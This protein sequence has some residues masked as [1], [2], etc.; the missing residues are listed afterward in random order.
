MTLRFGEV[1]P[2]DGVTRLSVYLPLRLVSALNT[3]EH[4]FARHRRVKSERRA[5]GLVVR[6]ALKGRAMPLP[7]VV[8]ITRIS[9]RM[10]DVGDNLE[11]SAKGARDE[12]ATILGV[13]DRDPRVT[14]QVRQERGKPREFGCRIIIEAEAVEAA[15]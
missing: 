13:N 6:N 5:V 12:I 11:S 4:P 14:W 9:S 2:D 7:C 3:R 15:P 8:T 10:L 1:A